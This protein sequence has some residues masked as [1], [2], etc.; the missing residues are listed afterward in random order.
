MSRIFARARLGV[1]AALAF[2]GGLVFAAGFNLT[3]FGY[4][5]QKAT[6]ALTSASSSGSNI[7]SDNPFVAIAKN[8]TPAVVYI[9]TERTTHASRGPDGQQ[10]PPGM[11]QFFH[12]FQPQVPRRERASGSGFIVSPDGYILTNNHVVADADQVKVTMLDKRVYTAKVVGRDPSTDVAV[13]KIDGSNFPTVKLGD[14]SQEQVGDWVL[15]IGNPLALK[16]SVTAGIISAKGR[17]GQFQQL[18]N[19]PQGYAVVDYIQTDAAINP[20]N[21]GGPLVDT[22]GEVIGINSAIE[23]GTGY[24]AGYGFAIP[25][26]LAKRVMND[27]IKYGHF[28]RPLLGISMQPMGPNDAQAAGLK[29]IRGA[30]VGGFTET[31]TPSPAQQAGIQE[32]DIIIAINGQP[33]ETETDLQRMVLDYKPGETINVTVMRYGKQKTFKVKLGKVPSGEAVASNSDSNSGENSGEPAS[34]SKLGITIQTLSAALA[35]RDSVPSQYRGVEVTDVDRDGSAAAAGIA[36][37]MII[38]KVLGPDT[39]KT[40]TSASDLEGVL[41]KMHKGDVVSLLIYWPAQ[42]RTLVANVAI[43]G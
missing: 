33:V 41:K 26:T 5:Q 19:A 22:K 2:G 38:T 6:P 3:P 30:K 9:E 14:D 32:G 12:Q 31:G 15:A 10:L 24:Y 34:S 43:G 29:E 11:E 4:A 1:V 36:P 35:R 21:S 7:V 13:I 42:A 40:I 23:S 39:R 25:I 8:V 17:S 18:Y 20:G 16:F 27:L 37:G 28:N